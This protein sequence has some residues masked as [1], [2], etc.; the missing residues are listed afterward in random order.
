MQAHRTW[1]IYQMVSTTVEKPRGG[2][3][4]M[5][6]CVSPT[7]NTWQIKSNSLKRKGIIRISGSQKSKYKQTLQSHSRASTKRNKHK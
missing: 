3:G 2:P 1:L 7:R 6:V 4:L 5:H